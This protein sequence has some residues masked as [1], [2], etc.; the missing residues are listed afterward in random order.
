M[1]TS[2]QASSF[3]HLRVLKSS[4]P[5][6]LLHKDPHDFKFNVLKYLNHRTFTL[7]SQ[8]TVRICSVFS[9][10]P[11]LVHL[12]SPHGSPTGCPTPC[13][14]FSLATPAK[15]RQRRAPRAPHGDHDAITQGVQSRVGDGML[16]S[17]SCPRPSHRQ[18]RSGGRH[19]C[20]AAR[21]VPTASPS[22]CDAG[23]RSC[24][25]TAGHSPP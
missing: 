15:Y 2:S 17:W 22:R 4:R 23:S 9:S 5:A 11:V 25:R 24:S 3:G 20:T 1:L 6:R 7:Q 19:A 8:F 13:T 21:P 12:R 14:L 16:G 18:C 10:V